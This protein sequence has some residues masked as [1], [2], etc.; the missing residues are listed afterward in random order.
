MIICANGS[1]RQ[2]RKL[3]YCAPFL[4]YVE[5]RGGPPYMKRKAL[6]FKTGPYLPITENWIYTQI[7][8]VK[9]YSPIVYACNTENLDLFPVSS[10]RGVPFPGP[11]KGSAIHRKLYFYAY[12]LCCLARDKPAIVHAHFGP[13]GQ[14][15]L[16]LKSWTKLPL[17]TTFYGYDVNQL[18]TKHPWWKEKYKQ[19]FLRGDLFLVEGS[20]MRNSLISLGCPAGKVVVQHLGIDLGSF[21]FEPRTIEDNAEIKVLMSASFREKKGLTYGIEG[22]AR[23][24]NSHP[25]ARITLTIIGDS[26]GARAE[27][28]EKRAILGAIEKNGLG[29]HVRLLGYQPHDA[30][31]RELYNHHIFMSPSVTAKDLDSEGGAPVSIIEASASGMPIVATHHCDIPEVV[32]DGK[33]GLLAPERDSLAIADK[34]G[35]LASNRKRWTDMGYHGRKHV[36]DNYDAVKQGRTLEQVYDRLVEHHGSFDVGKNARG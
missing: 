7:S 15:F 11:D 9:E 22:F 2:G 31:I 18:I 16:P 10:I 8:N 5:I 21:R 3:S 33:S 26:S 20:H 29:A 36:E 1:K 17:V 14:R 24:R 30:F 28:E 19:L 4:N 23:F 13:S 34:I 25:H 27:E 6:H 32:V 12:Y 35:F